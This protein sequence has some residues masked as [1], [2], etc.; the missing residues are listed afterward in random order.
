MN[1]S[2]GSII[3]NAVSLAVVVGIM[4]LCIYFIMRSSFM[5]R[6]KEI[7]IYRAIGVSKKNL[8]YKYLI[9]AL[10]VTTLTV[11][12]GYLLACLFITLM[13]STLSIT[14]LFY[15]PAW[16]GAVILIVIY[17][18]CT[19]FGMLPVSSLLRKTPAGILAKYDI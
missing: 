15:F 2:I 14:S 7:G 11:F 4:C 17:G 12:I 1:D 6:V 16:L 3:A 10:L 5:S 9:E 18:F 13:I 8:K 19:L